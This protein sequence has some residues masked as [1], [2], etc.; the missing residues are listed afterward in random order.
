MQYPGAWYHVMNRGLNRASIFLDQKD[1]ESFLKVMEESCQ[2]YQ[3]KVAAYCL[4]GNH[5]HM[6]VNTPKGNLARFLRHVNGV[7]TQRF[8]R[9]HKRD[10]PLFRGRYKAILIEAGLY[11][12]Q[13]VRYVHLNPIEAKIVKDID[14]YPWTSHGEYLNRN[15]AKKWVE[16]DTVL[17]EFGR[18]KGKAIAE[19]RRFVEDG[20]DNEIKEFYGKKKQEWILGSEDFQETIK[21]QISETGWQE[22]IVE[23]KEV[24]GQARVKK[25]LEKVQEAY[26][27]SKEKL[28][29]G[30]RGKENVPKKIAL[31]LAREESGM[32]LSQ[33]AEIFGLRTYRT[34]AAHCYRIK[35]QMQ[36]DEKLRKIYE[37]IKST[38]SQ[39]KT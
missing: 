12:K 1:Y 34:V 25:V 33:L 15:A 30:R 8:N 23:K 21:E 31:A 24:V 38:C 11:L 14:K 9:K 16:V 19:Y 35:K 22:E 3:V 7:Y 13:L 20:V 37:K 29:E 10:G 18:K 5:Y 36:K 27:I 17:G 39:E 32:T 6:V 2:L 28:L 26:G 4:M